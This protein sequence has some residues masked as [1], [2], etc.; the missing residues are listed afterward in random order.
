M[1]DI[2]HIRNERVAHG[3]KIYAVE[4]FRVFFFISFATFATFVFVEYVNM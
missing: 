3:S 1:V 2:E 4:K